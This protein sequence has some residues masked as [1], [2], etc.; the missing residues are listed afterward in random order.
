MKNQKTNSQNYTI[1]LLAL[2]L[3]LL[4][5]LL[6]ML[7]LPRFNIVHLGMNQSFKKIK[8]ESVLFGTKS[9]SQQ[10]QSRKGSKQTYGG[11][12][13]IPSCSK[14][15]Y[16]IRSYS[17]Y[18]GLQS[19]VRSEEANSSFLFS[20]TD[21]ITPGEVKTK[22]FVKVRLIKLFSFCIALWLRQIDTEGKTTQSHLAIK[23][24]S[25]SC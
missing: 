9:C 21:N 16:M 3:V 25:E 11:Q 6:S 13:I 1:S 19:N 22:Q 20:S 5:C 12:C 7:V 18:N 15:E 8:Q 10:S 24:H 23:W 17:W 4:L 14:C 2:C